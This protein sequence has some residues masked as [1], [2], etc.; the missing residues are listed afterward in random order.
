[1]EVDGDPTENELRGYLDA[2]WRRKWWVVAS[3]LAT[4]GLAVLYSLHTAKVYSAASQIAVSDPARSLVLGTGSATQDPDRYVATQLLII[5]SQGVAT[6]VGR[7]MGPRSRRIRSVSAQQVGK[8][9]VVAIRAESTSPSVARDGA[10]AYARVYVERQ[11]DQAASALSDNATELR[12]L[13]TKVDAQVKS[14]DQTIALMPA[15]P[16]RDLAVTNRV[17]LEQNAQDLHGRADQLDVEAAFVRGGGSQIVTRASLPTSPI[18]PKP[19]RDGALALVLGLLLGIGLAFGR[20]YFDDK[21]RVEEVDH[22]FPTVPILANVPSVDDWHDP[23]RTQVVALEDPHSAAAEAYRFLRTSVEFAGLGHPFKRLLITSPAP[24]EGKSTTVANLAV[25]LAAAGSHVIIV[26]CDLRR[27]RQHEFFRLSNTCGLTTVLTERA[28]LDDALQTIPGVAGGNL[29]LLA[30]GALPPDPAEV[31]RTTRF[32]MLLDHL[33]RRA[34]YVLIDSTPVL[35]VTDALVASR[36]VDGTICVAR[37]KLTTYR[38]L[39]K[40]LE[41]LNQSTTPP[42]GIVVNGVTTRASSGTQ[43]Y[44]GVESRRRGFLRRRARNRRGKRTDNEST[45]WQ[46]FLAEKAIGNGGGP[47]IDKGPERSGVQT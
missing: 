9:D 12:S 27:P 2:L 28:S 42:A 25:S 8:T 11:R 29:E 38:R 26:D 10:N 6:D 13:A 32:A 15:G 23:S 44:Y 40:A 4:V 47:S 21:V 33:S 37:V 14:A 41:R 1:M 17:A 20:E 7:Q 16:N 35:S 22:K 24:L 39:A 19:A 30:S 45:D 3:V 5:Q 18:S 43:Y 46:K 34:D 31:L 36:W